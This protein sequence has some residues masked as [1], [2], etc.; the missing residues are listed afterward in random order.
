[1]VSE[2]LMEAL[3]NGNMNNRRDALKTESHKTLQE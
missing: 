1:M 2:T 3:I